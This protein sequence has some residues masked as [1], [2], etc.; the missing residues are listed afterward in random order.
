M[1]DAVK[2]HAQIRA[3]WIA[4]DPQQIAR[5]S[6]RHIQSVLEDAQRDILKRVIYA[7]TQER[8]ARDLLYSALPQI[9]RTLHTGI[10]PAAQLHTLST[11]HYLGLIPQEIYEG[12][13]NEA[14]FLSRRGN[15]RRIESL[16]SQ[17]RAANV[18]S[19]RHAH[20]IL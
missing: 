2:T 18:V 1:G 15:E 10:F 8:R 12:A 16:L 3:K 13:V 6:Q 17:E 19:L 14:L 5:C 20:P 9:R 11:L 4:I 7:E